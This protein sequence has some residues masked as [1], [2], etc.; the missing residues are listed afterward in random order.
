[1]GWR[2]CQ[3]IFCTGLQDEEKEA[4]VAKILGISDIEAASL[5]DLVA[6]GEFKLEQEVEEESF[7]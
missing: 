7:F 4:A 2:C 1:M 5:R 6:S 3:P